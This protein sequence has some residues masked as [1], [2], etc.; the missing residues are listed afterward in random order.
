ML[1]LI[2]Q[3]LTRTKEQLT[4]IPPDGNI[5]K[6]ILR[7]QKLFTQ[8]IVTPSVT[9]WVS[10]GGALKIFGFIYLFIYFAQSIET[11]TGVGDRCV[12]LRVGGGGVCAVLF[13]IIL[14]DKISNFILQ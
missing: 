5:W 2:F 8:G 14:K 4:E 3:E 11:F 6:A 1:Y 9:S 12:C 10:F 13:C 7:F